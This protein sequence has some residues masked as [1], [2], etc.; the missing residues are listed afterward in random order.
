MDAFAFA[1]EQQ[2]DDCMAM[3]A[4]WKNRRA[5]E[6]E[7]TTP[8]AKIE[9]KQP[10]LVLLLDDLERG[11]TVSAAVLEPRNSLNETQVITAL[12]APYGGYMKWGFQPSSTAE[13]EWTPNIYPLL[14]T[15]D[16]IEGYLGACPSLSLADV[17]VSGGLTYTGLPPDV[18]S[19]NTWRW[20]VTFGG[21]YAGVDMLPLQ[22]ESVLSGAYCIVES[23]TEWINTGRIV[24]VREVIGVPFPT[25]ARRGARAWVE[26][27]SRAG[28]CVTAIEP[29]DFGDYGLYN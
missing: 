21:R 19:H 26:W 11:Q 12:G 25:P 3:I 4:W 5:E 9:A 13:I 17:T 8:A 14:D 16:V 23:T 1:T 20:H 18:V 27:K 6:T 15:S 22:I 7:I 2:L 29:R 28:W 24:E 10:L